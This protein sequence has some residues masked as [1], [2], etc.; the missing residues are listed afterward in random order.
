MGS[1]E[2]KGARV[3]SLISRRRVIA[4]GVKIPPLLAVSA[5]RL[6]I[7]AIGA[8][9][10]SAWA[11]DP[12]SLGAKRFQARSVQALR[13]ISSR[14][15]MALG[16]KI[17]PLGALALKTLILGSQRSAFMAID[18]SGLVGRI[19][20][21]IVIAVV[22]GLLRTEPAFSDR[23][24]HVISGAGQVARPAMISNRR[25]RDE[26]GRRLV[27]E[28]VVISRESLLS[29]RILARIDLGQPR[30]GGLGIKRQR[31][32]RG[33]WSGFPAQNRRF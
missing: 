26:N 32:A 2:T 13:L 28:L 7:L 1:L 4:L 23:G 10:L 17:S 18:G 8:I 14:R 27:F 21:R 6:I 25:R 3:F 20:H 9:R 11:I 15:I 31:G 24:G 29:G 5:I 22:Q 16:V 30:L 19:I 12:G 33:H